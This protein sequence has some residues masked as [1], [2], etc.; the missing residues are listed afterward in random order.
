MSEKKQVVLLALSEAR[1]L[2]KVVEEAVTFHC[3][4]NDGLAD[5]VIWNNL[6]PTR[7]GGDLCLRILLGD[8]DYFRRSE[9]EIKF[10]RKYWNKNYDLIRSQ[11]FYRENP[12]VT[13]SERK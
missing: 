13:I 3:A 4:I 6:I 1:E 11:V 5:A 8:K 7:K 9:S 10:L 12:E 2:Y